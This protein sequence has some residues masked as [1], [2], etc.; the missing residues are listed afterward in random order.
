MSGVVQVAA[1]ALLGTDGTPVTVEAG[2]AR[3]LPGIAIVGLPDAA[4][5]EAKQR[6]RHAAAAQGLQLSDRFILV[7]L[8]PA[9]LPKHG[10]GFDLAI[11]LAV[12]AVSGVVRSARLSNTVH[13]GELGLDGTVRRPRGL[14]AAVI[15]AKTAGFSAVMVPAEGAAEASLVNGMTVIGVATLSAAVTWHRGENDDATPLSPG[16]ATALQIEATHVPDDQ[17]NGLSHGARRAVDMS[18][19]IGQQ[20]AIEALTIAAAGRHHVH[21]VGPPGAG[22]TMLAER[23]P[24]ILPRLSD[25]A[26]LRATSIHSLISN[27]TLTSLMRVPPFEHPHHTASPAAMIGAARGGGLIPGSLSLASEGVLFLDEAAE[28][29]RNVLDALRQPLEQG[30]VH[31]HRASLRATLPAS[32]QL[33]LAHNPCPCGK[34]G[35]EATDAFCS[36]TPMQRRRYASRISGP[37][38]DRIDLG[39]TLRR[40]ASVNSGAGEQQDAQTS[41]KL[42][43]RVNEARAA[44]AER[45]AGT[46]WHVN[47]EVSGGWLR[48]GKLRLGAHTTALLDRALAL[49]T[50]TLRGYD[51]A[52]RVAWSV[53]DLA[54][55][56]SPGAAEVSRALMFREARS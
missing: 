46:P 29:S 42:R 47:A 18:E 15:A 36:C 4:L 11:A 34:A 33:V 13:I 53:A 40:V 17:T 54:G 28:F 16:K 25:E 20:V 8:Q 37:L 7:N 24:T 50:L 38:R 35:A 26:S 3:R 9:E 49:G 48:E 22:K 44:A 14:L 30:K 10:S 27:D 43:A 12:L 51:R 32:V 56:T 55:K 45:L 21:F 52:L 5:G 6:V 19:V 1:M 23:L 2:S 41:E 31:I 39:I